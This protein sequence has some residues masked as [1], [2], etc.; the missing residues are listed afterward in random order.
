MAFPGAFLRPTVFPAG[1]SRLMIGSMPELI[2]SEEILQAPRSAAFLPM[3]SLDL[4][5]DWSGALD[6]CLAAGLPLMF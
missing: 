4:V 2:R 3:E 1:S 5:T 6:L